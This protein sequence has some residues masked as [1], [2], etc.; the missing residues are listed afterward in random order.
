MRICLTIRCGRRRR[1]WERLWR[2]ASMEIELDYSTDEDG[3]RCSFVQS[4]QSK[5]LSARLQ[6]EMRALED[7][8]KNYNA[9]MQDEVLKRFLI[10][11]DILHGVLI[12]L[13]FAEN[14]PETRNWHFLADHI[15]T[16]G[17]ISGE[18]RK[19]IAAV[20]RGDVLKS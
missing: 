10:I 4:I 2:G 5:A 18:M 12:A 7:D 16:G 15:E 8:L 11:N 19:F 1:A 6:R 9:S 3:F 13:E 17:L 14:N 20:L